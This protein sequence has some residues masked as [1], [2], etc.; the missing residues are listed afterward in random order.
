M[1]IS[2]ARAVKRGALLIAAAFVALSVLHPSTTKAEQAA[3]PSVSGLLNVFGVETGGFRVQTPL[4]DI[5]PLTARTGT[6]VYNLTI[7][8]K[9]TLGASTTIVC[10]A[11]AS[12]TEASTNHTFFDYKILQATRSGS[13]AT[14]SVS[15]PYSW[16][17]T[18]ASS[19]KISEFFAVGF[20]GEDF[21]SE[22]DLP[23]RVT[24]QEVG[25]IAVPA[26]GTTTTVTAAVTL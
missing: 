13:T 18:T 20:P 15:I 23:A 4:Q 6:L 1:M 17:L 22:R 2:R 3:G 12:T 21:L 19:D 5:T 11:E 9:S 26:S 24:L 25:Q 16:N 7:T 8:V 10:A 14:C